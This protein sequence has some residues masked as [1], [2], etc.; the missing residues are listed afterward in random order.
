M[1]K[2]LLDGDSVI[3]DGKEF[4]KEELK[5]FLTERIVLKRQ[6]DYVKSIATGG[7]VDE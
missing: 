3:M 7:G 1:K 2:I 5:T 6:L 4:T